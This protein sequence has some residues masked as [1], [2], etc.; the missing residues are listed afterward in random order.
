MQIQRQ[1]Q[2]SRKKKRKGNKLSF[3]KIIK[4]RHG[5]KDF[6][7]GSLLT[8]SWKKRKASSKYQVFRYFSSAFPARKT[9]KHQFNE[10]ARKQRKGNNEPRIFNMK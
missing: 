3:E 7:I 1:R 5:T 8:S 2:R 9:P 6:F 10:R 4:A